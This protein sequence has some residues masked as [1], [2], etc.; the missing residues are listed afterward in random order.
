MKKIRKLRMI[1]FTILPIAIITFCFI[2]FIV[3]PHNP[4]K[5]NMAQPFLSPCSEYPLGTDE[6][7]RCLFSR[8]LYGGYT[9][10]GIVLFGS[11]IVIVIGVFIG[12]IIGQGKSG[13]NVLVESI[14]NAVTAIPPIAY[15]IIFISTWGNSI[16]TMI[17]ALTISLILRMI[18]LIKTKTEIEFHKAYVLC[19][20][21][22]GASRFRILLVHILPNI[23]RDAFRFI[24]LSAG[25]MILSIAGFSFIGLSLGDEVIDWG[26]MVSEGRNSFGLAPELVFYPMLFI[27]LS[28]LSFNLLGRQM[29]KGGRIHA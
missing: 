4:E 9:T 21:S 19:A 11:S 16:T 2:G 13:Q 8:I 29:E 7:G 18:K 15:L 5:V 1:F 6:F 25:E 3:A 17:V 14:L 26:S 22:S 28:V 23:I 24:C 10:L 12:L 20:V 27:F